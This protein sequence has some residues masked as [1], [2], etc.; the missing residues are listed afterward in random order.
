MLSIPS[1]QCQ[2]NTDNVFLIGDILKKQNYI[3]QSTSSTF[4]KPN[5]DYNIH[6]D[7]SQSFDSPS[8]ICCCSTISISVPH[9]LSFLNPNSSSTINLILLIQSTDLID[10][11]PLVKLITAYN[12]SI[13]VVN[14]ENHLN[15]KLNDMINDLAKQKKKTKTVF[16]NVDRDHRSASTQVE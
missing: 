14:D 11:N 1:F 10:W 9:L 3:Q 13:N 15:K 4:I 2:I 7:L 12:L 6:I 16:V 8:I 5:S